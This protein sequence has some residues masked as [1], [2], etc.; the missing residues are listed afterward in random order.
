[1]A[2]ASRQHG[3]VS[4]R[5]LVELGFTRDAIRARVRVG[6]LLPLHRGVYAV[7]HLALTSRSRDLA[8][9]LA[10]GPGALLSHRSA[11]NLWG[12]LHTS[13][14]RIEVTA[15]RSRRRREGVVVHRSRVIHD[16]D[17]ATREAIPVTSLARTVVDLAEVLN[18]PRLGDAV[19]EAEV[20]RLFDLPAVEAAL[21]RVPGRKGGHRLCRVL[22]AYRP[23]P[24]L[25][26]NDAERLLFELCR[27]HGLP[28]P[29]ANTSVAGHDLDLFWPEANLGVEFD[30]FAVHGTRRAFHR[31][32]QK[33]RQLAGLGIH[34]LRVTSRDLE[35]DRAVL[36][37]EIRRALE[38]R[39]K[40]AA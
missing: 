31:D 34:V 15:P 10:C 3:V 22:A 16:D 38:A 5:Q 1:V 12:I 2:L 25:L 36:A 26:R 6:R 21:G 19:N 20:Q 18:E 13:T 17:R 14:A 28:R 11:G 29:F 4:V 8:A 23:E 40:R 37:G 32:R 33:D 30:G 35:G 27:R 39:R 7:G 24:V 9:V